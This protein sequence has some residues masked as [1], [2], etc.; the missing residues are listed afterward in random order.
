M[1]L[2]YVLDFSTRKCFLNVSWYLKYIFKTNKQTSRLT[3]VQYHRW[4]RRQDTPSPQSRKGT[5]S[6]E[7]PSR[8]VQ[9]R[10]EYLAE[11][12]FSMDF[13]S[14]F[15][16]LLTGSRLYGFL[17]GRPEPQPQTW[18]AFCLQ[19]DGCWRC[20]GRQGNPS[21]HVASALSWHSWLHVL[22][23]SWQQAR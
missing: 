14:Q 6:R 8:L 21:K 12:V 7:N 16:E 20:W 5:C 10:L 18:L 23:G 9:M 17:V 2:T 15:W 1:F 11:R 19:Q 22:P 3:E 13:W 4:R